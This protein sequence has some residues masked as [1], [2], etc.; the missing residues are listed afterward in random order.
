MELTKELDENLKSLLG[1]EAY[2]ALV[3]EIA[4]M[5]MGGGEIRR[6]KPEVRAGS[7][8]ARLPRPLALLSMH[9]QRF[10]GLWRLAENEMGKERAWPGW[11]FLPCDLGTMLLYDDATGSAP[12]PKNT[13]ELF[14]ATRQHPTGCQGGA[15]LAALAGWRMTKGIYRFD[16]DVLEKLWH[17]PLGGRIPTE[18]LYRL[19]EWVVYVE[20]PEGFEPALA[21]LSAKPGEET[22]RIRGFWAH[23]DWTRK[24]PPRLRFLLDCGDAFPRVENGTLAEPPPEEV[25]GI[26]A[27]LSMVLGGD[28]VE[29]CAEGMAAHSRDFMRVVGIEPEEGVDLKEDAVAYIEKTLAPLVSTVL[30]LCATNTEIAAADGSGRLPANPQPRKTKKRGEKLFAANGV[31]RWD[32]AWRLG[33]RLRKAEEREAKEAAERLKAG[34]FAGD[35]TRKRPRGHIRRAHWHSYWR[36]PRDPA[37]FAERDLVLKWILP[38]AINVDNGDEGGLPAVVRPVA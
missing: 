3:V 34:G 9:R 18:V 22:E 27:P 16:A 38:T 33:A 10:P 8:D 19:P 29:Q 4:A 17:T 14:A 21:E 2:E 15:M 37:R 5:G 13:R 23:L 25:G 32:V 26:L 7:V 24:G 31:S 1:R 20:F 28:T 6:S 11:C 12:R 30:Y 36:G 35:G